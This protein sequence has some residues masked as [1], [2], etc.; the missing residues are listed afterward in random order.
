MA[1]GSSL[2]EDR[3]SPEDCRGWPKNLSGIIGQDQ[4]LA[5]GR[6]WTMQWDFIGSLLGDSPKGSGSSQGACRE[7]TV[8]RPD[9]LPQECRRLPD[10]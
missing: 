3:D 6:V 9:D 7:I 8:R 2:E 1:Q 10:W 4:A 5:L